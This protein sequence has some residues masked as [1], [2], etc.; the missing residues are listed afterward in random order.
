MI[1][2]TTISEAAWKLC[3]ADIQQQL[4]RCA[5]NPDLVICCGWKFRVDEVNEN[6]RL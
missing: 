4:A 5:N 2:D 1:I 3:I 6:E